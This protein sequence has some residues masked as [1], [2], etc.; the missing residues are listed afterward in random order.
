MRQF[1]WAALLCALAAGASAQ[2]AFQ[3]PEDEAESAFIAN[4]V[5]ATFYHELGHALIDVLHL[6]VLG[7]QEDAADHRQADQPL[8][9]LIAEEVAG[10]NQRFD[11]P[12]QVSVGLAD[13]GAAL[14]CA[15]A[16]GAERENGSAART[17]APTRSRKVLVY[18]FM[19]FSFEPRP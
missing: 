10:L 19:P 11:L 2:S 4:E 14:D 18:R 1:L 16:D 8:A 5:I 13:C 9:D 7:K 17:A 12:V 15:A 3:F 6:P